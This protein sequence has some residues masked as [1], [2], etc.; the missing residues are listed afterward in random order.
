MNI[1]GTSRMGVRSEALFN[2]E[3][4]LAREGLLWMCGVVLEASG[5]P[6]GLLRVILRDTM[7][8]R[9]PPVL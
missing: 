4:R 1:P 5:N 6:A 9:V 2:H 3:V 7:Q 8:H